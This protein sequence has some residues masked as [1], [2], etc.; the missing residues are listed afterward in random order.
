MLL[1]SATT[2]PFIAPAFIAPAA[3]TIAAINMDR[4]TF[5]NCN[6][7]QLK[8]ISAPA[9]VMAVLQEPYNACTTLA[10]L[11]PAVTAKQ[12]KLQPH[13]GHHYFWSIK[14]HH[15]HFTTT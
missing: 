8:P 6:H 2:L 11:P 12:A 1:Q 10:D 14:M 13:Q 5:Y 7:T 3:P 9:E 4:Y 15:H